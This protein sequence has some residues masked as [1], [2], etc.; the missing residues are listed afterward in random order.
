MKISNSGHVAETPSSSKYQYLY[1]Y[2]VIGNP[3]KIHSQCIGATP[4]NCMYLASLKFLYTN[5]E[6]EKVKVAQGVSGNIVDKGSILRFLPY[7]C[8]G[9]KHGCQDIGAKSLSILRYYCHLSLY[10][11]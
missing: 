3:F 5:R 11:S 4:F 2:F 6:D 8:Q 1:S 9:L 7:I 10:T